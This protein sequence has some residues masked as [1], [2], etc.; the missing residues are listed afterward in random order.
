MAEAHIKHTK[1]A[2]KTKKQ[3]KTKK[4][5]RQERGWRKPPKHTMHNT[6]DNAKRRLSSSLHPCIKYL[7]FGNYSHTHTHTHTHTLSLSLSLSLFLSLS[8]S[9]SSLR[10]L[11]PRLRL[12][13]RLQLELLLP[14]AHSSLQPAHSLQPFLRPLPR[15]AVSAL[16]MTILSPKRPRPAPPPLRL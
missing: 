15:W 2:R 8:L 4:A 7:L 11:L 16:V 9:L 14:P 13:R 3:K 5:C 12:R 1:T 6:A 10:L